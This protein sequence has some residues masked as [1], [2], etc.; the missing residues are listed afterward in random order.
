MNYSVQKE[1][2]CGF[3]PQEFFYIMVQTRAWLISK[4]E[5]YDKR[6]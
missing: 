3:M 1:D 4:G 2:S 6:F 5:N